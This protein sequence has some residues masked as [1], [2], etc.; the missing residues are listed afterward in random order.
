MRGAIQCRRRWPS[1]HGLERG[2]TARPDLPGEPIDAAPQ[3]LRLF[4]RPA[5]LEVAPLGE[6]RQFLDPRPRW[7]LLRGPDGGAEIIGLPARQMPVL[8]VLR[9]PQRIQHH[10]HRR[11]PRKL[12]ETN[13][14][15]YRQADDRPLQRVEKARVA[16]EGEGVRGTDLEICPQFLNVL[17]VPGD[18]RVPP[19]AQLGKASV[20]KT[21]WLLPFG[22]DDKLVEGPQGQYAMRL[23]SFTRSDL[24]G[25]VAGAV[26]HA[27]DRLPDALYDEL[28]GLLA[29]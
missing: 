22:R 5:D 2:R 16:P 15:H 13:G 19:A 24:G 12:I 18:P 25:V 21:W 29:R 23:F 3:G 6:A 4:D 27:P 7:T 8:V 17:R 11:L 1:V 10:M 28:L 9:V 20:P 26:V 14:R